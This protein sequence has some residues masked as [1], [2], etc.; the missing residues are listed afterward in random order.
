MKDT[1]MGPLDRAIYI[2][3]PPQNNQL[4]KICTWEQL[5]HEGSNCKMD[6]EKLKINCKTKNKTWSNPRFKNH[7]K[8]C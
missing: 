3:W 5:K 2:N 6:I 7:E 4:A 1:L 8:G